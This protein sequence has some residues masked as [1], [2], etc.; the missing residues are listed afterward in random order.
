MSTVA[1]TEGGEVVEAILSTSAAAVPRHLR[2]RGA[3]LIC[4]PQQLRTSCC[5][6]AENLSKTSSLYSFNPLH[7]DTITNLMTIEKTRDDA[8]KIV[9]TT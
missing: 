7:K 2:I 1:D 3:Q 9:L 8:S 6:Q 4:L 5:P